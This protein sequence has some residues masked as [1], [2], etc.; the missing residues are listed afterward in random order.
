[1]EDLEVIKIGSKEYLDKLEEQLDMF[2]DMPRT[3]RLYFEF[4]FAKYFRRQRNIDLVLPS[5]NNFTVDWKI[6]NY[7]QTK[8]QYGDWEATIMTQIV[9]KGSAYVLAKIDISKYPRRLPKIELS[10]AEEL[11]RNIVF[12]DD[13][14]AVKTDFVD[15]MKEL[16][17]VDDNYNITRDFE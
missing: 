8:E 9:D 4:Q 12:P 13:M 16:D 2:E 3:I 6:E 11:A 7:D 5:Q 17:Y 10:F 14:D 1:M 15:I